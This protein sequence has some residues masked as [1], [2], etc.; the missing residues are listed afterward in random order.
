LSNGPNDGNNSVLGITVEPPRSNKIYFPSPM[1][2]KPLFNKVLHL[3][4]SHNQ[5]RPAWVLLV[6]QVQVQTPRG[7][8]PVWSSIMMVVIILIIHISVTLP[9]NV[10]VLFTNDSTMM[11]PDRA[12]MT[13]NSSGGGSGTVMD[14]DSHLSQPQTA[15]TTTTT[16]A[17]TA[18]TTATTC[19]CTLVD[20][21][22]RHETAAAAVPVE[23]E[24]ER[25]TSTTPTIT[26]PGAVRVHGFHT[27]QMMIRMMM[28]TRLN[29]R[30]NQ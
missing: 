19:S 22:E 18:R 12:P 3:I 26:R 1:H 28:T 11:D 23:D 20:K 13:G 27:V 30:R 10:I 25:S 17:T 2:F 5:H 14:G 15:A 16:S 6:A 29:H 7:V 4:C 21:R 9:T 8:A 24:C